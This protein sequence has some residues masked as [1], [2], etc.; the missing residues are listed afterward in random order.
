VPIQPTGHN[1]APG[2]FADDAIVRVSDRE[3]YIRIQNVALDDA[4]A[5]DLTVDNAANAAAGA[6][7]YSPTNSSPV[8]VEYHFSAASGAPCS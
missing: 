6:V 3:A 7:Q 1:I 2:F 5:L 8:V 4:M